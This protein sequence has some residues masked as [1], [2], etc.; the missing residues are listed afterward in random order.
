MPDK[1]ELFDEEFYANVV[2]S[3]SGPAFSRVAS[4][5]L[6]QS[7]LD[8]DTPIDTTLRVARFFETGEI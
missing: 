2:D 7:L 3:L 6:A 4:F 8:F 1:S 5:L